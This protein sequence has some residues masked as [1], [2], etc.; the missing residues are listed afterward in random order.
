MDR[1][2]KDM[3]RSDLDKLLARIEYKTP[4]NSRIEEIGELLARKRA[5]IR[6]HEIFRHRLVQWCVAASVV[7]VSVVGSLWHFSEQVLVSGNRELAYT[8]PDGSEVVVMPQSELSYNRFAWAFRRKVSLDGEAVFSVT[9]GGS[10]CVGTP[11][12]RVT[13][14]GT[15]FRVKQYRHDM[16]VLCYEGSVQVETRVGRRVLVAGQKAAC[17]TVA[18]TL[19]DIPKPLPPFISFEAVP[20]GEVIRDIETIFGV[21]VSGAER[22]GG[23]VFTGFIVTSDMDATLEAVFRSC[24]IPYEVS[25]TEILLK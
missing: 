19:T 25:G 22:Y 1:K 18:I 6:R 9:H 21:S 11:A 12:G 13:V 10:F 23:L 4:V 7:V 5:A 24:G 8:L 17:D 20:L 16:Q 3:E 2:E 15:R 14:L